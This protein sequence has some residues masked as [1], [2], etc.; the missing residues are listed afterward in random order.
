M[1]EFTK[2]ELVETT[3]E[4]TFADRTYR[5][6][7]AL[8][9]FLKTLTPAQL[10]HTEILVDDDTFVVFFPVMPKPAGPHF[11]T[12]ESHSDSPVPSG[13]AFGLVERIFA[14]V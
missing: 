5:S 2:V 8:S 12:G 3:E 7:R 10:V 6:K 9:R 1:M 4:F 14:G 11:D 13:E